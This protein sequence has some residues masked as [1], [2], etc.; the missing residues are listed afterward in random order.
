MDGLANLDACALRPI[1]YDPNRRGDHIA[2]IVDIF[3]KLR[4]AGIDP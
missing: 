4:L 3:R 2:D 1:D